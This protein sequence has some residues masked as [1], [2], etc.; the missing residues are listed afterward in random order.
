MR[1]GNDGMNALNI[2]SL[3]VSICIFNGN[4]QW[5]ASVKRNKNKKKKQLYCSSTYKHV[6]TR[7]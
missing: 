4:R 3:C 5:I 6:Q 2:D 7:E 1:K